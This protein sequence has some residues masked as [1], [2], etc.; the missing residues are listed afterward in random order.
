MKST[1]TACTATKPGIGS[2]PSWL[3]ACTTAGAAYASSTARAWVRRK[4][5]RSCASWCSAGW[6][7]ARRSWPIARPGR[8][9]VAKG[10]CWSCSAPRK[11]QGRPESPFFSFAR[12][13]GPTVAFGRPWASRALDGGFVGLAGTDADDLL[14]R[15]HEDLAVADLAG[16]GGLDDGVDGG[17]GGFSLDDDFD[18]DL[19]QEVD[20]VFGAAIQFSMA[21]LTAK[22]L[23]FG[24]GQAADTDFRQRLAYLVELERLDDGVDFFHGYPLLNCLLKFVRVT[25]GNRIPPILAKSTRR[26][27]DADRCLAALV[28]GDAQQA[29]DTPHIGFRQA[30]G[31]DF[32]RA[33]VL[34]HVGADDGIE[35]LVG[36]QR[37]LVGLIRLQ[38]GGRRPDDDVFRNDW[39]AL[40]Q[41]VAVA[42]Q[43]IDQ[44]LVNLFDN[45][46]ASD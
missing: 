20:D 31:D 45:G 26:D 3:H 14:D 40:A 39:I 38:F 4:R 19:G 1:C 6:P 9:M 27:A 24:D 36:R 32:A 25:I 7:S 12:F 43:A 44:S 29:D 42:R 11:R 8:M 22:T 30:G 33:A 10:R 2:L 34:F 15:H 23:D 21:L 41:A 37:I 46:K 13:F 18:L 16:A 5:P 28:F 17:F 35:H